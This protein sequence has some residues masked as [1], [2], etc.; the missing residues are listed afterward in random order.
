MHTTLA[1]AMNLLGFGRAPAPKEQACAF[2]QLLN[3]SGYLT[4]E[5]LEKA[6][7]YLHAAH[8]FNGSFD[9]ITKA[10]LNQLEQCQANSDNFDVKR[11]TDTFAKDLELSP[12]D[13][14]ELLMFLHQTAFDRAFGVERDKLRAK[15][16]MDVHR[17]DLIN[18]AKQFGL[19][20]E[21]KPEVNLKKLLGAGIMGASSHRVITRIEDFQR[22]ALPTSLSTWALSGKRELSKGLD[23]DDV[24][25]ELA[26]AL[27]KPE[28]YETRGAGNAERTYLKDITET[29][30][31]NFL[32]S[33]MIP[34]QSLETIDSHA[35]EGHWRAT[36]EQGARDIAPKL[37]EQIQQQWGQR[38]TA[39]CLLGVACK[40]VLPMLPMILPLIINNA[41]GQI[42]NEPYRFIIVAEQPYGSRMAMQVQRAINAEIKKQGLEIT[43]QVDVCARAVNL[44]NDKVT[45]VLSSAMA[46]LMAER[47]ND[48]R[49]R[50][51]NSFTRNP[52]SLLFRDRESFYQQQLQLTTEA[53]TPAVC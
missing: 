36:T 17:D 43:I 21:I 39:L 19:V 30:M 48:A 38:H 12:G 29:Q 50:Y 14:A 28:T 4:P 20:D 3:I 45:Q 32:L 34:E 26:A 31:V 44:E 11:F 13:I 53:T 47:Y 16:W 37:V 49:L 35:E 5:L 23:S 15:P 2:F 9:N 22:M 52:K 24:M 46:P 42:D 25:A 1:S 6:C 33:R 41:L 40:L 51:P 27:G 7:G 8:P 18:I 10:L